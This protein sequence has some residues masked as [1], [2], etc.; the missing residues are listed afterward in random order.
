[1][2]PHPSQHSL[3][4]LLQDRLKALID[5]R[6]KIE[7]D[8]KGNKAGQNKTKNPNEG[9]EGEI[10]GRLV[11]RALCPAVMEDLLDCSQW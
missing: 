8:S 11:Q 9:A 4:W 1:M 2:V 5:E 10:A 7:E 3:R 6:R